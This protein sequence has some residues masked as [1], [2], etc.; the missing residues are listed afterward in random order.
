MRSAGCVYNDMIDK[1]FDAKVRRTAS[2]PL[3]V[4]EVSSKEAL[5]VLFFFLGGV[6]L[7]FSVF[8]HPLF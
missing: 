1:D 8:P 6:P 7:F 3:A 4:G 2:R 5:I